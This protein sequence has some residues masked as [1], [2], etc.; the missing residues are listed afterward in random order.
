MVNQIL[1]LALRLLDVSQ[2]VLSLFDTHALEL[3][4]AFLLKLFEALLVSQ[5]LL[6]LL[7]HV[8]L[9]LLSKRF[10]F[11]GLSVKACAIVKSIL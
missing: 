9:P 4:F 7:G 5:L 3:H 8:L 11:V 2:F 10:L 1:L 6:I